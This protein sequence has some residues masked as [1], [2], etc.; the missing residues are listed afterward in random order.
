MKK[1][2]DAAGPAGRIN[3]TVWL[4]AKEAA[5]K[6]S[7]STDTVERR[8]IPWQDSP[9]RYKVRYKYLVLDEGAEPVRRY[10]EPDVEALLCEPKRLPVTC[11]LRLA[12][13]RSQHADEIG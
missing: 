1:T 8:A 4:S 5:K 2:S 13:K 12:P 3:V 7:V 9:E 11:R 10:Y 6:L